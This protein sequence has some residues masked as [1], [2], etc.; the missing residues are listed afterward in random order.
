MRWRQ[1]AGI[2]IRYSF[3]PGMHLRSFT[4]YVSDIWN[5]VTS[6]TEWNKCLFQ[7]PHLLHSSAH[8]ARCCWSLCPRRERA[9]CHHHEEPQR[10]D[11]WNGEPASSN[12]LILYFLRGATRVTALCVFRQFYYRSFWVPVD[13]YCRIIQMCPNLCFRFRF[14]GLIIY[15][16]TLRCK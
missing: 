4:V 11:H 2:S 13:V 3:Q 16:I 9:G 1:R 6:I 14:G 15:L 12:T 7:H 5:D 8:A 10:E